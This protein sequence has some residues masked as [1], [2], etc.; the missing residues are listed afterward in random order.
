MST[1]DI[2]IIRPQ[3]DNE[4]METTK[5]RK[6]VEFIS[7]AAHEMKA[8]LQTVLTY[9]EML[10][11]NPQNSSK[12][13]PAIV[14]NAKRLQTISKNLLDLSRIENHVMTLSKES[15]DLSNLISSTIDDVVPSLAKDYQNLKVIKP[16]P[17]IFV[18]ADK[19]KITQVICNLLANAIKFTANGTISVTLEKRAKQNEVITT[20]KDDGLG[21]NTQVLP[22][23]FSKFASA[24]P[25][26]LGL[27]LFITKNIIEAHGGRIWAQNNS[28]GRGA[29]VSFTLPL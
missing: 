17:H 10:K 25:Q 13:V 12:Y 15:F 5:H 20:V 29:S 7:I 8:P 14:R 1:N 23:L 4:F 19:D 9:S 18:D 27:G 2:E 11:K 3:Y 24:S 21:I 26:G 6:E 28:D 16:T 22:V